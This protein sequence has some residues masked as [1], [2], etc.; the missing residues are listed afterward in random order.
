[1]RTRRKPSNAPLRIALIGLFSIVS[2]LARAQSEAGRSAPLTGKTA[3]HAYKNIQVLKAIPADQLIPSMQFI[4]ASLGVECG[5]CHVENHFDQDDKKPKQVA[6]KMMQMM[7]AIN[8]SNF[9]NHR[10]V[11]CNSCH[12]GSRVPAAIPA[13]SEEA[14][15]VHLPA[16]T[17]KLPPGLPTPDQL[18]EKYLA[19][20]GGKN[21]LER[22]H[23]RH[24]TGTMNL[25]GR[26][27]G[28]E[29]FDKVP[30]KRISIV[31]LQEG[32]ST[33]A[34]DGREGWLSS[35]HRPIREMPGA[36][37]L[38]ARIDADLQFPLHVEQFF[39]KLH[40]ALPEKVADRETY[41]LAAERNGEP[42]GHLYFDRESGL[43]IRMLRYSDSALGLNPLRIDYADY[44]SVGGV[45]IP[46]RW[47]IARPSG[48]F[49]I[50]LQT[51]EQNIQID[52]AK[53]ARPAETAQDIK[54]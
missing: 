35:P 13:I 45:Q 26:E 29:A 40:A 25:F 33:T 52:D 11:T 15:P 42:A 7:M 47:T 4:S 38:G 16:E 43:L 23:S 8:Q 48:Q 34:F 54:R 31:H 49:T 27:V 24:V 53:F 22:V 19:A 28:F 17:E 10:S 2:V 37:I 6:R 3:E 18:I 41:H 1:M 51:V 36:D 46:F 9:D 20:T 44:R 32:D 12:H 21:A 39:G 50:Q 14:G 30:Y 5:Y